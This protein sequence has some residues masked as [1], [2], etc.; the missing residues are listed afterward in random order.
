MFHQVLDPGQTY[1]PAVAHSGIIQS[2]TSQ[3]HH[4]PSRAVFHLLHVRHRSPLV[5]RRD[6]CVQLPSECI[7]SFL[8]RSI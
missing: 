3:T 4:R 5:L 6:S 8:I 2:F 1:N 7:R